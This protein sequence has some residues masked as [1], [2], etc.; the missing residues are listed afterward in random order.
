MYII[1]S[2]YLIIKKFYS[3]LMMIAS[4]DDAISMTA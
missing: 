3:R 4:F 2:L 1:K